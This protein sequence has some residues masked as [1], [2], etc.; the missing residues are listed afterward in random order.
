MRKN[1]QALLDLE[2]VF[3]FWKPIWKTV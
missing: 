1:K 2:T 3:Y